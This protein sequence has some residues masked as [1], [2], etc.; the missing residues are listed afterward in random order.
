MLYK[1]SFSPS[2]IDMGPS[3]DEEG[4]EDGDVDS[5]SDAELAAVLEHASGLVGRKPGGGAGTGN[6]GAGKKRHMEDELED[7]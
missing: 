3:G 7:R 1:L 2:C 4:L 5:G 6:A